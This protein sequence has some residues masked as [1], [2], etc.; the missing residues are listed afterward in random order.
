MITKCPSCPLLFN[1]PG[2]KRV[3]CC[4]DC[5][6]YA[7]FIADRELVSEVK[8][9]AGTDTWDNI[10]RRVGYANRESLEKRLHRLGERELVTQIHC[11]DIVNPWRQKAA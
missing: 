5:Y 11:C 10:A 8:W 2:G 7:K 4:A 9:L 6:R 1:N 3:Y